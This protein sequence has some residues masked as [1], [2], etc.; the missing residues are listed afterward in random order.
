M[1][2]D[3]D[4][5][6][7]VESCVNRCFEDRNSTVQLS[8]NHTLSCSCSLDCDPK[9]SCCPDFMGEFLVSVLEI[10]TFL[11]KL[12]FADVCMKDTTNITTT[13]AMAVAT[14]STEAVTVATTSTQATMSIANSTVKLTT[15]TPSTSTSTAQVRH[16]APLKTSS[17]IVTSTTL[18]ST[19]PRVISSSLKT[20]PRM[21]QRA[22]VPVFNQTDEK[23][24]IATEP[25]KD[26]D[27]IEEK[28]EVSDETDYLP[29]EAYESDNFV[30]ERYMMRE[31]K[32]DENV[33]VSL[34]IKASVITISTLFL[35]FIIFVI[36][37]L[38][39]KKSTNPL[40]Y[41]EKNEHGSRKANEE[42]S[43]IRYLT[44]DETLDFNLVTP[45][46]TE[47]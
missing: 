36:A 24:S 17:V 21:P 14:T 18:T 45:D 43:E 42:F 28:H 11:T 15:H 10:K 25:S 23:E 6:F 26:Y 27:E 41:K 34:I 2:D 16:S 5:V 4:G 38:Q 12:S 32:R 40:N 47:L 19:T 39:Y 31:T 9:A 13:E 37:Y 1:K 22:P 33:D 35:S 20:I 30:N 29:T 7:A 44:S 3:D 46:S 8:A